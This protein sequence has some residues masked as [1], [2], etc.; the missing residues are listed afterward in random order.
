MSPDVEILHEDGL[1]IPDI[2]CHDVIELR[3]SII[4]FYS[5]FIFSGRYSV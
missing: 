4:D 1:M 5:Y 3:V 2:T